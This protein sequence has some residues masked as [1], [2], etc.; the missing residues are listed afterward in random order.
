MLVLNT[1]Y[2]ETCVVTP[3]LVDSKQ[4]V[5]Y[6]KHD[7]HGS[8]I[9]PHCTTW[10]GGG[11]LK[12]WGGHRI[13]SVSDWGGGGGGHWVQGG[14]HCSNTGIRNRVTIF[15]HTEYAGYVSSS[16]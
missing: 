8:K 3:H 6:I 1:I 16:R 11:A 14:T 15:T 7:I 10:E 2:L 4:V 12:C 5:V 13:L 9:T